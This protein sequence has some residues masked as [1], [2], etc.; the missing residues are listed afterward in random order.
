MGGSK[1]D[2]GCVC[3]PGSADGHSILVA[4]DSNGL[5]IQGFC[6][7]DPSS[8]A[9]HCCSCISGCMLAASP[10]HRWW[11]VVVMMQVVVEA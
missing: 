3:T 10:H 2:E 8:P 11:V 5:S 6:A 1:L 7:A 9:S 4:H